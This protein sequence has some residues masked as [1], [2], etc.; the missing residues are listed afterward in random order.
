M[1]RSQAFSLKYNKVLFRAAL[2][3]FLAE[4]VYAIVSFH[5]A[6]PL[7]FETLKRAG[8]I[9]DAEADAIFAPHIL[10]NPADYQFL[11]FIA[12][13]LIVLSFFRVVSVPEKLHVSIPSK[14]YR[15]I[16]VKHKPAELF[17][18]IKSDPQ[19]V[20]SMEVLNNHK[21]YERR[22]RREF[23]GTSA[24]LLF[25]FYVA[26]VLFKSH[27]IGTLVGWSEPGGL[28]ARPM[29]FLCGI[30][31]P[32]WS[33]PAFA[34]RFFSMVST[35][36]ILFGIIFLILNFFRRKQYKASYTVETFDES[37][38]LCKACGFA[39]VDILELTGTVETGRA[40]IGS[41]TD[42]VAYREHSEKTTTSSGSSSTKIK[43]YDV[44][45]YRFDIYDIAYRDTY[46]CRQCDDATTRARRQ[47][48]EVGRRYDGSRY[49]SADNFKSA[50]E[51]ARQKRW[52]RM[53]RNN[54]SREAG[55]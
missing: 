20:K 48:E 26:S 25:S 13:I 16:D 18:Q 32:H 38:C 27:A 12:G 37:R 23:L 19:Y 17:R 3:L 31:E 40:R 55:Q 51:E 4:I 8:E 36:I 14:F 5:R 2:I 34:W 45:I 35:C 33:V 11:Y 50:Q 21:A 41:G 52:D 49:M 6:V 29:A 24:M 44:K 46:A 22:A 42:Y 15:P 53:E 28:L 7:F 1:T 9:S 30:I 54:E 43:G 39:C 10:L 47:E